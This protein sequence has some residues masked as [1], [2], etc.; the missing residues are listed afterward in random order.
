M[1]RSSG[2]EGKGGDARVV[3]SPAMPTVV[4]FGAGEVEGAIPGCQ[5]NP[6]GSC[7]VMLTVTASWVALPTAELPV[8]A[9][10]PLAASG[11]AM[12]TPPVGR[13]PCITPGRHG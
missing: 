4:L 6:T 8:E 10:V 7:S 2:A 9:N 11:T 1:R 13:T 12:F 5:P 3:F